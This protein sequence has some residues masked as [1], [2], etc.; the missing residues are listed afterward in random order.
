MKFMR[1]HN[2]LRICMIMANCVWPMEHTVRN[3]GGLY[4]GEPAVR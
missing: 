1:V 4:D 3:I 2:R